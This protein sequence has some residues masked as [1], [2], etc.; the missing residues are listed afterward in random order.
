MMFLTAEF[1]LTCLS[2]D[3]KRRDRAKT[4]ATF[5]LTF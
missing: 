5:E 2:G 1:N 3:E 4:S